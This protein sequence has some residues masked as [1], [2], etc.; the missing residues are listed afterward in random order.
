VTRR[1]SGAPRQPLAV[2]RPG[3]RSRPAAEPARPA[4]P[5][6]ATKA[7]QRAK[8]SSKAIVLRTRFALPRG[9]ALRAHARAVIDELLVMYPDAHCELD[10][11]DPYELTVATILSAQ[12]TD[13]RVNLT[14]PALFARYP[15]APA[16]AAAAP[17]DVEQLVKS[18][19]FF[20]AKAKNLIGMAQAVVARHGGAIPADMDALAALP[21]VGRKTANVVLGNA[22]GIDEGIVVDTHVG[23]LAVRLGFTKETD[24]VKVER[25]LLPLVPRERWTIFS[26]LLIFHGRRVCEA[27]LPRCGECPLRVRCPSAPLDV[28]L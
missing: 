2:T 12:C 14:T 3:T 22:F 1:A 18:T 19:G 9:E 24:P 7:A 23:R 17:E 5:S 28:A 21:G 8:A 26:H 13:K 16:L 20:R 27:R 6:K 11:R 4:R 15:D 25:A 10:F